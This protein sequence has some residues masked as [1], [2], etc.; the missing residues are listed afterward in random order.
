M[1][2]TPIRTTTVSLDILERVLALFGTIKNAHRQLGLDGALEYSHF[3]RALN[4]YPVMP[5]HKKQVEDAWARWREVFLRPEV[6]V[7]S[8][9]SLG[10][11]ENLE[12]SWFKMPVVSRK[13]T[14]Y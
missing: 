12:P 4:H 6:P 9:L 10:D 11:E 1:A 3:Y 5:A 7:S 13:R 14:M 8:M 2:R